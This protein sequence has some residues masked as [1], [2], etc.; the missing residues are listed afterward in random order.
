M[1]QGVLLSMAD[2]YPIHRLL[3]CTQPH[4]NILYIQ[5]DLTKNKDKV[6]WS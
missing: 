4:H 5:V 1:K 6:Y 3:A 2:A